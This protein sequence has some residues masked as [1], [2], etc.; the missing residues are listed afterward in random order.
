MF[1]LLV[2]LIVGA[3]ITWFVNLFL[4]KWRKLSYEHKKEDIQETESK[5]AEI[6]K[7]QKQ[8]PDYEKKKEAVNKFS[9]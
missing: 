9:K 3:I 1:R 2:I 4:N 5:F 8:H 6:S 7:I